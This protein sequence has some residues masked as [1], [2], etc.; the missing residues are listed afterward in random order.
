MV[1]LLVTLVVGVIAVSIVLTLLKNAYGLSGQLKLKLDS[2]TYVNAFIKQFHEDVESAGYVDFSKSLSGNLQSTIDLDCPV[3]IC[4]SDANIKL[5]TNLLDSGQFRVAERIEYVIKK[6]DPVRSTLHPDELG[7]YKY[8]MIDGVSIYGQSDSNAL[9]LAGV[10]AFTCEPY[11]PN[12]LKVV[13]CHLTVYRS[14]MK[15]DV[16]SFDLYAINEN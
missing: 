13:E 8:R 5:N 15:D 3:S 14:M 12:L 2:Q 9:V 10:K 7:I 4:V 16:D 11:T 1:E 6:I